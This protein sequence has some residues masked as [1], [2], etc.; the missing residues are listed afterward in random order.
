MSLLLLAQVQTQCIAADI[1]S[2]FE[3]SQVFRVRVQAAMAQ[4]IQSSITT[5][6]DSDLESQNQMM[7]RGDLFLM[8]IQVDRRRA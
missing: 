3:P 4:F 7:P 5:Q 6:P 1:F 2:V 8:R